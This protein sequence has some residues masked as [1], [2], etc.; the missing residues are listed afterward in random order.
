MM[1]NSYCMNL[2][3][4]DVIKKDVKKAKGMSDFVIVSCHWGNEYS[5]KPDSF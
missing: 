4:E 1:P 2:F 3:N 5:T